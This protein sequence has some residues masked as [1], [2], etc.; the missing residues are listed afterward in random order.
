[1]NISR[2]DFV[3]EK[4][5]ERLKE[6]K[7]LQFLTMRDVPERTKNVLMILLDFKTLK[8]VDIRNNMQISPED[9]EDF[10]AEYSPKFKIL[11]GAYI[12]R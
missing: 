3:T 4:G 9:V 7:A 1:M 5:V 6:M 11:Y 8:S 12:G 2:C 10:I